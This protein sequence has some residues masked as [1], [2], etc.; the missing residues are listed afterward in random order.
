L[1]VNNYFVAVPFAAVFGVLRMAIVNQSSR[2][3]GASAKF[4]ACEF[5]SLAGRASEKP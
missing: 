2:L 4:A 1:S 3:W 5:P